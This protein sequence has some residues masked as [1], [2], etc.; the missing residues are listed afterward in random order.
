[1]SVRVRFAP[2]PTGYLHIGSVWTALFTWMYARHHNGQ[3][4][5]RIED[6]D[7]KR[8]VEG[9]TE[10]LMN[11]LRWFGIEWDEGPDIGGPHAPYTQT[12]RYALYQKWGHWLVEQGHAYKCFATEE[13]LAQIRAELA[14]QGDYSGYDRRYRDMPASEVAKL[15]AEDRPYAIR[16]KMPL[17]G[18]TIMPDL[19]RG[20]VVFENRLITDYILLKSNGLPTYHLAHVVD[21]HF[22]E[23]SH[24]TRGIEWL[25]TAPIHIQLWKA[26]GWQM[27]VYVHFPV[28]L[29][30]NG[31]GKL[32]KRKRVYLD[33]GEPVLVFSDEFREAGYLRQA[34]VNFLANI[35]WSFGNDIEK[36]TIEE[37]IAKFDLADLSPAP[38][39]LP[40]SKLDWLNGQYIQQLPPAELA[41][42][43]TPFLEKA[44]F[45]VDQ[46]ALLP[47][48]PALSLRL[49]RL[50][51]AA[52]FLRFLYVE[53]PLNLTIADLTDK[54]IEQGAAL[55]GFQQTR[56][57]I[58]TLQPLQLE[59]LSQGMTAIG[60]QVTTNQKAGTFLGKARLAITR[61]QVSPPLFESILAL[62]QQRALH[63]LDEVIALLSQSQ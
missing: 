16:L 13:E 11:G 44:G 60:K 62:G 41:A 51:E 46:K 61:Q 28:I 8:S 4:I 30:P 37:A 48:M 14:A 19:L 12:E 2:S 20:D 23:I 45:V 57:L 42:A 59:P 22:M 49:K 34:L 58:A 24:V 21:D 33:N 40:Y 53:D 38:T 10:Y 52:N 15:E 1:M 17:E 39:R 32:S 27:P 50:T 36:F 54:K 43:I 7:Q 47:V 5:L 6:T 26:F 9:A 63:R 18:E 25:S 3:F 35:G 29:N 55:Q 56:N 31:E